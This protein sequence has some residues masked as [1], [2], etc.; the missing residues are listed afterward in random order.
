M[1]YKICWQN[2]WNSKQLPHLA[3]AKIC[4][5]LKMLIS[6]V[7]SSPVASMY[8]RTR[9][10]GCWWGCILWFHLI[11]GWNLYFSFCFNFHSLISYGIISNALFWNLVRKPSWN[12]GWKLTNDDI[13]WT[14]DIGRQ[15]WTFFVFFNQFFSFHK[16]LFFLT[17]EVGRQVW[18]TLSLGSSMR[19]VE[20]QSTLPEYENEL[21]WEHEVIWMIITM[22]VS[23]HKN[24]HNFDDEVDKYGGYS[25]QQAWP[26][27]I[28]GVPSK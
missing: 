7:S 9:S 18:T 23:E 28:F 27:S 17:F 2:F 19:G 26:C 10:P 21:T 12:P 13:F 20:G 4:S 5:S 15:V 6:K 24:M 1:N 3:V 25:Q 11:L 22:T 16:A 8:S 14:F